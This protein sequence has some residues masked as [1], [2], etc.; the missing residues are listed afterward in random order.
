M[1]HGGRCV[2]VALQT[3]VVK[4]CFGKGQFGGRCISFIITCRC[5]VRYTSMGLIV[6][7]G[8]INKWFNAWGLLKLFFGVR[9][10]TGLSFRKF[11]AFYPFFFPIVSS[12]S[13]FNGLFVTAFV[14]A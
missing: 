10:L 5:T 13:L 6:R 7:K 9:M 3:M 11:Y 1:S 4:A 8:Y 12:Q 2:W 14:S